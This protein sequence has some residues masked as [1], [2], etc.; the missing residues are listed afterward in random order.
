[1]RPSTIWYTLKQG[2]KNI[3]RNW[4]FS[5]ASII[6]MS[7]C[8][9]LFGIFYSIVNNVKHIAKR[10]EEQVPIVV[11]FNEGTTAEEMNEVG[12]L[13]DARPEVARVEF[14]SADDAWEE[15]QKTYFPENSAAAEGFKDDNPLINSA[16]YRVYL[17]EIERQ[18]ETVLFIEM[19]DHVREVRQSEE[20]A[21][22]LG[23]FNRIFSYVSIA[24]IAILLLISIF[25][26]SNTIAVGISVRSEEISIMKYIGATDGFVRAPFM[27]EGMLLGIIGAAIP[28]SALYFLY[29]N[30]I[31]YILDKFNVLTGVVEFIS[32]K[33]IYVV[34]IPV[35]IALGIGIGLIGSIVTT[36][37]HLKA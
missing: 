32:V 18:Q 19:Q 10:V 2:V 21:H 8:I 6:V 33:Q 22:T 35:G 7:A 16:N 23:T 30:T 24:V 29:N 36:K 34:L 1:M 5:L 17:N 15:F 3:G 37:K 12:K 9:F 25:L 27:L 28:L 4:M 31:Q 20:A 11:F 13:I 26:I 14:Q